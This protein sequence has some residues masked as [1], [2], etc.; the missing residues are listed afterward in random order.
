MTEPTTAAGTVLSVS[1]VTLG[2]ELVADAAAGSTTITVDDAG[3]FDADA[4]GSVVINGQLVGYTVA[5]EDAGVLTLAVPLA[6][7]AAAGDRV[8]VWD[9][10]LG[11][12]AVEFRALVELPG[13]VDN[14]D[15]LEAVVSS[16]V[17]ALLP[18]GLR[19]PGTGES[20]TLTQDGHEWVVTDVRGRLPQ[21]RGEL[22]TPGS[23]PAAA[24]G[25]TLPD[26]TKVTVDTAAPATPADR[27]LWIDASSDNQV[28]RWDASTSSWVPVQF[29]SGAIAAGAI[30]ADQLAAGAI[31]A[32][33]IAA[34]AL[35]AYSI[36]A[37]SL[38]AATMQ[39]AMVDGSISSTD[40]MVDAEGGRILVYSQ[41]SAVVPVNDSTPG[42]RSWTVPAGVT[43]AKV[44][45]WGPGGGGSGYSTAKVGMVFQQVGGAGGGGGEYAAETNFTVTPGAVINYTVGAGGTGGVGSNTAG[46][47]GGDT[48]FGTNL[49]A[50]VTAHG[51]KGATS[52]NGPGAGGTGSTNTVKFNGGSGAKD[53]YYRTG[54][55]DS[56]G[57]GG[58]SSAGTA[59]NGAAATSRTGA[60]APSGGG[61]GGAGGTSTVNGTA[62]TSPGGGGGGAGTNANGAASAGGKVRVTYYTTA[63]IASIAPTAGTDPVTGV[64][65]PAG[66]WLAPTSITDWN[67]ATTPGSYYGASAS[68]G[69]KTATFVGQVFQ[70]LG[71]DTALVQV[72]Y[73]LASGDSAEQWMRQRTAAGVW[74]PWKRIY[75]DTGLVT[76]GAI[77]AASGATI[78]SYTIRR[79]GQLC[80]LYLVGTM[81]AITVSSGGNITN[82]NLATITDTRFIPSMHSPAPAGATGDI[83]A[84]LV[85]SSGV[86]QVTAF[87]PGHASIAAG[88]AYSLGASWIAAN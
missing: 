68:N 58:G 76:S 70:G 39:G 6:A 18:E 56:A 29:G 16:P 43:R 67:T 83:A 32:G 23:V 38:A 22:L 66:V 27:D 3:E 55:N 24:L 88:T 87:P 69:P 26:G 48:T 15:A 5:D 42:S 74:E 59:A 28:N 7:A 82:T 44:E 21:L 31:V 81:P 79:V 64:S 62:G 2:D 12:V 47:N 54:T 78:S 61:N 25:F 73:R 13:S 53:G 63:L 65:Y 49:S 51:G 80:Q 57:G 1:R 36:N 30:T 41:T 60:T 19:D 45:C 35:D 71:T 77:T 50:K 11:D 14:A 52:G 9:V 75:E 72:V 85:T 34:G 84:F 4:G 17:A 46:S 40:F 8:D 33:K 10:A 20:V 37:V 86:I